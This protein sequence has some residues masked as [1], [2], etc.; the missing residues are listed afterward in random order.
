VG[1]LLTIVE[2]LKGAARTTTPAE[3]MVP[4]RP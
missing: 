2:I 3:V 4:T 1:V